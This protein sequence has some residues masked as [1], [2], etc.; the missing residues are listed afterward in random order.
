MSAI[1]RAD[2]IAVVT[3]AG[4]G[5]GLAIAQRLAAD[6]YA[7]AVTDIDEAQ[8]HGAA[9]AIKAA[10]G[11]AKGYALDVASAPQVDA[12]FAAA[13]RDLGNPTALVNNAGIW[14]N[15]PFLEL[16]AQAWS[17]TL[18]VNLTGPFLCSQAFARLR[19][20]DGGGGAIVNIA[21]VSAFSAREAAADYA[22]SK[23][24]LVMLTRSAA[25]ELGKHDI[26]VNAVAP[27]LTLT[28]DNFGSP[29]FRAA[30]VRTMPRGRAGRPSDIAATVAF[31]LSDASDFIDGECIVADG[32]FLAGRLMPVFDSA[33]PGAGD[34]A[35]SNTTKGHP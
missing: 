25:W 4:R 10:G 2:R 5:L 35:R 15:T 9:A 18:A 21:S 32:G 7:V 28:S 27:G 33:P 30:A 17:R 1:D 8:A 20:A 14:C 13:A 24:G 16:S 26:R 19:L 34:S 29:E 23:A 22:A 31:L 3:G 6:G 12:V 11:R